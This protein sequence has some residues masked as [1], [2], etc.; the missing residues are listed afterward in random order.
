M[1]L[2]DPPKHHKEKYLSSNKLVFY[3]Q[4]YAP[5]QPKLM[6]PSPPHVGSKVV[7]HGEDH[8]QGSQHVGSKVCKRPL[9]SRRSAVLRYKNANEMIS[10]PFLAFLRLC[11]G[12]TIGGPYRAILGHFLTRLFS[13]PNE[14]LCISKPI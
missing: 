9:K 3:S 1:H 4:N 7:I 10:Q 12:P 6:S 11:I 13:T 8:H 2:K 14:L 5:P